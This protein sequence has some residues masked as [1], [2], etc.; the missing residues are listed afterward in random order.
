LIDL[1]QLT[2]PVRGINAISFFFVTNSSARETHDQYNDG[3]NADAGHQL[4]DSMG[5]P[6]YAAAIAMNDLKNGRQMITEQGG[7]PDICIKH[8]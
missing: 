8:L 5:G 7:L 6:L 2:W 4:Y 1:E 3:T